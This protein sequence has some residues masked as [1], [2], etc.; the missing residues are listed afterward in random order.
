METGHDKVLFED[1]VSQLNEDLEMLE[2][3]EQLVS[4]MGKNDPSQQNELRKLISKAK[5]SKNKLL[6][7]MAKKLESGGL[8]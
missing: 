2:K 8:V 3:I 4:G 5:D 1:M 7:I 6:E